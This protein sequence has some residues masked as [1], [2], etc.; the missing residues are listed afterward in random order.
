MKNAS[1]GSR[2]HE[3][4][5]ARIFHETHFTS[6]HALTPIQN[7]MMEDAE[8]S[9]PSAPVKKKL[10]Q[11]PAW[12]QN[13]AKNEARGEVRKA[14]TD[15]FSRSND[16]HKDIVAEQERRRQLKA[17]KRATVAKEEVTE[18]SSKRRRISN[19]DE[20]PNF[21]VRERKK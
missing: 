16:S 21:E 20:D 19:A 10:F 11:K 1:D 17:K 4:V 8:T 3:I 9:K 14:G 5:K 12:L 2:A 6:R 18:T 7:P 13:Q 15:L